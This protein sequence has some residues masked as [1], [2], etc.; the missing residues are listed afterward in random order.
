[1]SRT[2]GTQPHPPPPVDA[3]PTP[4]LL[5]SAYGI[6]PHQF[7]DLR[8]PTTG[9][10]TAPSPPRVPVI[11]L[12]HGGAWRDMYHLDL[13]D[14]LADDLAARGYATW[15]L[16]YRRVGHAGG[17]WPG[18]F[19]DVACG[20]DHLRKLALAHPLDLN[21]VVAIGHSAGGHL[22]LWLAGRNRL[23][24][25][26]DL[27]AGNCPPLELCGVVAQAGIADL[28]RFWVAGGE[29]YHEV[30][31]G[32]VGGTPAEYPER[33]RDASPAAMLPL[34]VAQVLVHGTADDT[35][36][37]ELSREYVAAAQAA[38]DDV[39]LIELVGVD[40]F[41]VLFPDLR[42]WAPTLA[43]LERMIGA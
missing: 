25:A 16:E 31:S 7:G 24:E 29:G 35:V 32:L 18:T 40:H 13:M 39:E 8:L 12:I 3:A 27:R 41:A 4:S 1:M 20:L 19:H 22:A 28:H 2:N 5:R 11:V 42:P 6:G 37:V 26:S 23:P 14:P 10:S 17:G 9:V 30:M 33:W 36:P 21:R 15:N 38:G 34:G 43:A